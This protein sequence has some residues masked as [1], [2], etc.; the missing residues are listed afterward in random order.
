MLVKFK[1]NCMGRTIQNFALFDKKWLTIFDEVF[2]PIL[3][4]VP[5]IEVII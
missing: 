2:T 4:D 1:Q 5:M 3:E